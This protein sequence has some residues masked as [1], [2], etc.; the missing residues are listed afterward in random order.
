MPIGAPNLIAG[1]GSLTVAGTQ[2]AVR[3]NMTISPDMY[4]REGLAG[5]DRVHGYRE[6]PR[7]PYIEADLSIQQAQSVSNLINLEGGQGTVVAM[8]ADGRTYQLNQAWYKGASEIN[9]QDGQWRARFEGMSCNE[10]LGSV[11]PPPVGV[12]VV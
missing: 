12:P 8:L 1:L 11:T 2:V 9:S 5:Q 3:A 6:M 4:E 10:V 7:V